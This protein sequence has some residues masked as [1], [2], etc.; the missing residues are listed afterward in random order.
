MTCSSVSKETVLADIDSFEKYLNN[1]ISFSFKNK[2]HHYMP[3]IKNGR[4]K[5]CD[6]HINTSISEIYFLSK[7]SSYTAA[8]S[9]YISEWFTE[10]VK[11]NLM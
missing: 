7:L 8:M 5:F 4:I 3:K 11:M 1:T 10:Y 2:L 9:Y 6:V